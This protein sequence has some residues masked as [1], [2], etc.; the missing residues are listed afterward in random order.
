MF[1]RVKLFGKASP[2]HETFNQQAR[3][4]QKIYRKQRTNADERSKNSVALMKIVSATIKNQL[5][6][7]IFRD[8]RFFIETTIYS[9]EDDYCQ[10][11]KRKTKRTLMGRERIDTRI[12]RFKF[13]VVNSARDASGGGGAPLIPAEVDHFCTTPKA[14]T[15][16]LFGGSFVSCHG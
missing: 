1:V 2:S 5:V 15:V 7:P 13:N 4:S 6:A 8:N 12:D 16:L 9:D 11:G 3:L 14:L 10:R